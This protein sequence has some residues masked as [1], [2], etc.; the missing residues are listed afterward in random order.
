LELLLVMVEMSRHT[1]VLVAV[2]TEKSNCSHV[3]VSCSHP[4]LFFTVSVG[5]ECVSFFYISWGLA[6]SE[7]S[8][9][10]NGCVLFPYNQVRFRCGNWFGTPEPKEDEEIRLLERC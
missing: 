9:V 4:E 7:I 5:R 3:G 1:S 8:S 6:G 10:Y 2:V